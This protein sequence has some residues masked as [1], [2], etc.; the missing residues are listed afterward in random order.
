MKCFEIPKYYY[1]DVFQW[2][3]YN[4]Y[5]QLKAKLKFCSLK[6]TEDKNR[7]DER[8]RGTEPSFY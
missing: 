5:P 8:I 1:Q 2:V 3:T 6:W 4:E 7:V